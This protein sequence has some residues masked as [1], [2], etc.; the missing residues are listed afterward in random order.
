M[1]RR[2][3]ADKMEPER[4]VSAQGRMAMGDEMDF[5]ELQAGHDA[6]DTAEAATL[7][8]DVRD[9]L[10]THVRSIK[11]PW[12]M[13]SEDEQSATISALIAS[14]FIAP[15]RTARTN[16]PRRPAR[17]VPSARVG[18]LRAR[19]G[20]GP[21]EVH[22][23]HAQLR[24]SAAAMVDR[25]RGATLPEIGQRARHEGGASAKESTRK[26]SRATI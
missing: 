25:G 14:P 7:A 2:V 5:G 9:V 13:L 6:L 18:R 15:T 12:A 21:I 24:A 1:S 8:G 19:R 23:R 26:K 22:P 4:A 20:F 16:R 10:L 3:A 17:T 11:V